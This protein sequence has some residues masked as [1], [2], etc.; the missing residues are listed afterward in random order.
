MN[1][2][3]EGYLI[4]KIKFRENANIINVFTNSF[5]KVSGIVYGGNSRK[6]R[7]HLQLTNKIFVFYSS[8]SENKLGYFKTELV[9]AISPNFFNNKEKTSALLSISNILNIILPDS[10]PNKE[11]FNSL[12]NLVKK[13]D[14]NYWIILYVLWE[15]DLIKNLGF[16]PNL[17][18]FS[19]AKEKKEYIKTVKIDNINYQVPFFLLDKIDNFSIEKK[20]IKTALNFN[21]NLMLN[22]FFAPNNLVIPKSRIIL[23]NYFI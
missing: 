18:R 11:I 13:F 20:F 9:E 6:I 10:Q 19:E 21:R 23:E 17:D 12:N 14:K 16:D 7:N 15:L 22:K 8:K 2:Q 4:S 1:W 3:D 5:G